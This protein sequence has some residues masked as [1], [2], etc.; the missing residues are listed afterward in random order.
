MSKPQFCD[1]VIVSKNP[2][3]YTEVNTS[4]TSIFNGWKLSFFAHELLNKDGTIKNQADL[5]GDTLQKYIQAA[6]SLRRGEPI[7]KPILGVGIYDGIEIGVGR[8]VIAAAY[9]AGLKSIP[10]NIRKGQATEVQSFLK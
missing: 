1:H 8:E 10:A 3:D 6:E 9:H 5:S 7:E 2:D 4:P